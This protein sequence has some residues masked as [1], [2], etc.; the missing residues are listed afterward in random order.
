LV[1]VADDG[2]VYRHERAYLMCLYGL[3][4]Y[5][6]LSLW[7]AQPEWQPYARRVFDWLS[8]NRWRL[9]HCLGLTEPD[10]CL[11]LGNP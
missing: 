3:K 5:R 7:L 2:A 1:V 6:E 10:A 8:R 11:L 9:S 4:Q